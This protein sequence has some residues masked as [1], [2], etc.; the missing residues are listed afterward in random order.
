MLAYAFYGGDGLSASVGFA[1][2]KF[3]ED[4]PA[5]MTCGTILR[6]QIL[7]SFT[8]VISIVGITL[9]I[10]SLSKN[11]FVALAIA[12]LVHIAPLALSVSEYSPM[13]KYVVLSPVLQGQLVSILSISEFLPFCVSAQYAITAL[14][15]AVILGIISYITTRRVFRG[16]QVV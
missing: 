4:I 13:F 12:A 6:Y 3:F 16:H 7:L 11:A 15:V 1:A 2:N 14:P 9:I 5:D 8:S 10:S